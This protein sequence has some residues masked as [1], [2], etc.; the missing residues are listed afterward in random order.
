MDI[1]LKPL[2]EQVIVITGATSGIGL[3]TAEMAAKK[4]ARVVLSSR[5]ELDLQNIVARLQAAGCNVLGVKA[6]V[7]QMSELENLA[8]QAVSAFGRIDTWVN[9][10]GGSIYGY[11]LDMKEEE[12][13]DLFDTNF[14]GIRHG[15]HVAVKYLKD[16]GG[17]LI[18]LGS[19]VSLRSIPLQGIYAATKHAVKAYNDALRME[20]AH[21]QVPISVS[22]IRPT[23]IN[24]PF[25]D[26]AV[27]RLR[28]GEPSLPNPTYHP[29]FVAEAILKC[30]TSPTRD[31]FVGAPAK[32]HGIMEFVAPG[33]A[34]KMSEKTSFDGQT[35]GTRVPHNES[36]EGLHHAPDFEGELQGH[37]KGKVKEKSAMK[38]SH[39]TDAH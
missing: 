1:K 17:A 37:H 34:D 19:E 9:N 20:L 28:T 36:N 23:A 15:C 8:Q 5:N 3:A 38:S 31:V 24:T 32:I 2:E 27:N 33:F 7:R 22:L 12:E 16:K 18:N 4:G 26:H 11:L 29:D 35:A 10:A 25:P 14:W 39:I 30:A 21:Q 6:D 13:R